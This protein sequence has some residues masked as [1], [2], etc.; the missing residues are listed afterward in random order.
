MLYYSEVIINSLNFLST[1]MRRII[2]SI[3][4]VS[5]AQSMT[6][7]DICGCSSGGSYFGILPHFQ[8]S[9]IGVRYQYQYSYSKPHDINSELYSASQEY[10]QS[11]ELWGRYTPHKRI[12]IFGFLPYRFNHRIENDKTIFAN[13]IGDASL[14][15]NYVVLSTPSGSASEWR[16]SLQLGAGIKFP[17]GKYDLVK[18]G[19]FVHQNI[20]AGSGSYDVPA[21]LIY[22]VRHKKTG[23]NAELNYRINGGNPFGFIYGNKLNSAL[24]FLYW[25]E[26]KQFTFLPSVGLKYEFA[27]GDIQHNEVIEYTGGSSMLASIA[28]DVYYKHFGLGFQLSEPVYQHLG[29]GYTQDRSRFSANVIYLFN[30]K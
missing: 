3:L 9:F 29:Q 21:N 22:T 6:A 16:H 28:C 18:N 19:L 10:F 8:R 1:F 17:T 14:L 27:S 24:R 15:I 2:L 12:Q 26:T 25:K 11:T 5:L 23:M 13:G 7:C 20:Q 30:K 4:L